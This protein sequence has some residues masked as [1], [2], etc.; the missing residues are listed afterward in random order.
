MLY[1]VDFSQ[2]LW[3]LIYAQLYQRLLN[4]ALECGDTENLVK[5][6]FVSLVANDPS[7]NLLVE[8]DENGNVT[9]HC[10]F[11]LQQIQ[12]EVYVVFCEQILVDLKHNETFVK[13]CLSYVE[14]IPQVARIS[15]FTDEKKYKAFKK[16]YEFTID[17][18]L[19]KRVIKNKDS[20]LDIEE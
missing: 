12:P 5:S 1:K 20:T 2:E 7:V 13:D 10:L 9:S 17:K 14:N 8:V 18:V 11:L 6:R 4:F 3:R 16:K 15:M 19:M